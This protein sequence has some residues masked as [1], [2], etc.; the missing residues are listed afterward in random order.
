M[1]LSLG[2]GAGFIRFVSHWLS[3]IAGLGQGLVWV[4]EVSAGCD[5]VTAHPQLMSRDS[6]GELT[7]R[8]PAGN[9]GHS[10]TSRLPAGTAELPVPAWAGSWKPLPCEHSTLCTTALPCWKGS[11]GQEWVICGTCHVGDTWACQKMQWN[12]TEPWGFLLCLIEHAWKSC[13]LL[14]CQAT[15][16]RED[17]LPSQQHTRQYP[18]LGNF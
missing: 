8:G 10:Q 16:T 9:Q 14:L 6:T 4:A 3:W 12:C 5:W 1:S 15:G 18:A 7:W 13:N 11:G 17:F 2:R